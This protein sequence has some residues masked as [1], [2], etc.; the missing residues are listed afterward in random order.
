MNRLPSGDVFLTC[1]VK[2]NGERYIVLYDM[3][4]G[5]LALQ[6]IGRWAGNPQLSFTWYD[7]AMCAKKIRERID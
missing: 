4:Y 5:D 3:V 6:T 2:P 7:A 1:C